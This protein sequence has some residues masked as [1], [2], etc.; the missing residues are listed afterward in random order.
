M[1][2]ML[3]VPISHSHGRLATVGLSFTKYSRTNSKLFDSITRSSSFSSCF[4]SPPP[5]YNHVHILTP[6][7]HDFLAHII[8]TISFTV[9]VSPSPPEPVFLAAIPSTAVI[10]ILLLY[11]ENVAIALSKASA[12]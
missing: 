7:T 1:I 5:P 4:L 9:H 2:E 12:S 8:V 11:A 3:R 10:L 6:P